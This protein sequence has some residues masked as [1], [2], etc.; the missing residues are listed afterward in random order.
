M[1]NFSFFLTP[2]GPLLVI[3]KIA[4]PINN[5]GIIDSSVSLE[6]LLT[7]NVPTPEPIKDKIV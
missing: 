1:R 7:S 6:I 5:I 3:K 4:A 2:E